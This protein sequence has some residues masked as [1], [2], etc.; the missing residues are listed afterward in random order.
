MSLV[1]LPGPATVLASAARA[2]YDTTSPGCRPSSSRKNVCPADS[3]FAGVAPPEASLHALLHAAVH[4]VHEVK[5]RHAEVIVGLRFD[6]HLVDA[7]RAQVA[8]GLR[9]RHDGRLI[10]EH[11]DGILRRRAHQ[12]AGRACEVDPVRPVLAHL[13][14]AAERAVGIHRERACG[15]ARRARLGR[16]SWRAWSARGGGPSC[17]AA[18]R[19]RRRLRPAAVRGRCRPG[20]RTRVPADRRTAARPPRF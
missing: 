3:P 18:P 7:R 2:K 6:E 16:S 12:V 4:R 1:A 15:P 10:V 19:C 17:R 5:T 11:V 14:A 9:K 20:T 8:A 13:E